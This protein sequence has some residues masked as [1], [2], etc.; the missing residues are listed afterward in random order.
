MLS[1]GV[2]LADEPTAKLDSGTAKLVREVLIDMAK[3]R[4]VIVA[5]HDPR[6]IEAA[7]LHHVLRSPPHAGQAVAA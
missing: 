3:R 1:A 4:L 7:S 2:V 5:T 6:L